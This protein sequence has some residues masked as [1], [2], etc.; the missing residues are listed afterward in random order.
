MYDAIVIGARCAGAPTAMLLARKGC[1]V[2]LVDRATFPSDV[3]QGH[4]VHR[5]G[6]RRLDSWGLLE[7]VKA[8]NCPP[9]TS[10]MLDMG[11]HRL[12]GRDIADGGVP[13]GIAPRRVALDRILVEAAVE[14][15]VE[16]REGFTVDALVRDGDTVVG[17]RGHAGAQGSPCV[18]RATI[19]VG[20]D[21]RNSRVARIVQAPEYECV[22]PLLAWFFSYWSGVAHDGLEIHV[23]RNCA[24]FSAPTND[25]L[26]LLFVAWPLA[27]APKPGPALEPAFMAAIDAVPEFAARL[28]NGRREERFYGATHLP[29]FLRKPYGPGWAL[30]G[31]A[32]CHKDPFLALGCGDAL[33]DAELLADALDAGF[34]GRSTMAEALADYE[35]RRN[36][37][38]LPPYRENLALARFEPPPH[39]QVTLLAALEHNAEDTRRF[40]MAREELIPP[41]T[42][43]NPANLQRIVAGAA[44]Q[45][46]PA[47]AQHAPVVSDV[48][49]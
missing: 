22:P 30:V 38:T 12:D 44:R 32:G 21:G 14:A 47:R 27:D 37:A 29:N 39:E 26:L 20:A 28:R 19:T 16:L 13:F 40:F 25:G 15:G 42:F 4:F 1:K 9:V 3:P 10:F 7:R 18:E 33:R 24:R 17:I 43:F 11:G 31:D 35:R 8:S 6:P 23:T 36:A 45:D 48:R 46:C 34:S 49:P 5:N 41:Q 2:L